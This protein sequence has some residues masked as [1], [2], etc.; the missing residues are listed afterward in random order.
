MSQQNDKP[1]W[2]Y[3]T[4]K[5]ESNAHDNRYEWLPFVPLLILTPLSWMTITAWLVSSQPNS[6]QTFTQL[7]MEQYNAL[8]EGLPLILGFAILMTLIVLPVLLAISKK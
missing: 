7:F 8:F 1:I 3:K 5:Q 4:Y 6:Q 2:T